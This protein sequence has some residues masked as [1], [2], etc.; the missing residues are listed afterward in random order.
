[1]CTDP[2][3]A[4]LRP[5]LR[6]NPSM[7][8]WPEG[9]G[10]LEQQRRR[11]PTH[12]YRRLHLNLPGAPDGAFFDGDSIQK[13]IVPGMRRIAPV[14]GRGYFAFVDM[15]GGSSDDAC[16]A[17]AHTEA[18][19]SVLDCL[20][21]QDGGV[22]FDPALAVRKFVQI[23]RDYGLS[24]VTG[25]AYAGETFRRAFAEA[26]VNYRTSKLAKTDI[27]EKLEPKLNAGEVE[28]LD[29]PKLSEQL[30]TLIVRGARVDH[31]PGAHDDW[32]NAAAGVI[33]HLPSAPVERP[34]GVMDDE[35]AGGPEAAH[36]STRMPQVITGRM[37]SRTATGSYG[38]YN[39]R[40]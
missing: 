6:A 26:G 33:V 15:S 13:A 21:S 16:L 11:L 5:E 29:L 32:A 25:D 1:L 10:Y 12:K 36:R 22:P 24:R 40:R 8:S 14:I 27:Y 28:L 30:M 9:E 18:G 23:L 31:P 17:I 2:A 37:N 4:D 3:F 7:A 35:W 34:I 38:G 20:V 39:T 19:R